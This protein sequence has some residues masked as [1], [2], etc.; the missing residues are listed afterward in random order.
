[1]EMRRT[2]MTYVMQQ[3]LRDYINAQRAEAEEFSKQP[4]CWMGKMVNPDD[5]EYW[6]E[7]APCGTL[8]G[9]QRIEL[10]EDAYYITADR[11]SKSYA[12]S[13]DFANWSDK[14][15]ERHIERMCERES[16]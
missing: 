16:A 4:G 1:M 11:T 3:D 6:S 7:R 2:D 9:F 15:L 13:L 10:I 5:T 12:R 14:N 8:K